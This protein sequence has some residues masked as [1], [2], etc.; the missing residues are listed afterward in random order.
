MESESSSYNDIDS[1]ASGSMLM[2]SSRVLGFQQINFG[3]GG[4]THTFSP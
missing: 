1:R 4:E 3:W 2:T